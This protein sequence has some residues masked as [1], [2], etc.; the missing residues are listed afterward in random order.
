[1]KI[2]DRIIQGLALLMLAT[3]N[4]QL[5]TA[6]AQTYNIVDLGT[7]P[8]DSSSS[9]YGINTNGQVVGQSNPSGHAFLYS[10]GVM[11]DLSTP[12]G[13]I[14]N[15]SALAINN[16]GQVTGTGHNSH[17]YL[18][19]GGV[20]TDLGYPPGCSMAQLGGGINEINDNGQ[21]VATT[22]NGSSSYHACLN[23]GGVWT[24]LGTIGTWCFALG[25]NNSGQIFGYYGTGDPNYPIHAFLYSNGVWT[26]LGTLPGDDSSYANG[27]N[28]NGQVVG[29]SMVSGGNSHAFLYSSGV[30]TDLGTLPGGSSSVAFGINNKG[31]ILGGSTTA[32]SGPWEPFLYSA[33]TMKDMNNLIPTNSG[34]TSLG[35][36][37]I[38]DQGQIVG[39]GINPSG[40]SHGFLLTPNVVSTTNIIT[41]I[42]MY[43]GLTLSGQI[44]STYEIDYCNN[45]GT[46]NWTP[47]TTF[48][49]SNS[50]CLYFDTNSCW[51]SQRF[52]R[53]VLVP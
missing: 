52:Y 7:L 46:A 37:G 35:V 39:S 29:M 38:N 3:L 2:N 50:P 28:N 14:M 49:M 41:N 36:S 44:G 18:Y 12:P 40:Q 22:W 25:I 11:T 42:N 9:A 32:A 24:D 6:F 34:W 51:S 26:G 17:P 13:G 48:V 31:Q 1:M 47:L 23:S 43:A 4:A 33:G 19:S 8:G 5:S 15:Y 30:M 16:N 20:W 10:G 27:I 21:I 45:L 53:A